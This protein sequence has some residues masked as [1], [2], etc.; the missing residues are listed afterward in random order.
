[1][2]NS[3]R[4]LQN[5]LMLYF[6]MILT[7]IIG[8]YTSRVVLI[9]LGISDYGLYNV[10]GGVVTMFTFINGSLAAGTQRF[11]TFELGEGTIDKLKEVFSTS[12]VIHLGLALLIL[13]I[14][15][16]IG[17]WFVLTKMN[18]EPT[19][20]HAALWVY[21]FSVIACVVSVIQ[22][23]FM[24]ALIAYEK[25][26]IYAYMVIYYSVIKLLIFFLL[27]YSPIDQL[28]F[29]AFLIMLVN[30][31][32]ALIY[33]IYCYRHYNECRFS[34]Y[35]NKDIFKKMFSFSVWDIIGSMA[36]IGQMQGVNIIINLFCGTVV[37]AARAISVT[38]NNIAI[39]FV[40]NFLMAV[41]PQIV[42]NY[43]KKQ[44]SEMFS[45][46]INSAKLGSYLFLFISIPVFIEIEFLLRIWLIEYP[47]YTPLFLR[48]ILIQS[49]IQ[50]LGIPTVRAMHA[51]GDI[52]LMNM[53]VGTVLF[54]IL[55]ISYLLFSIGLKPHIV[56]II[57]IFPWL[58]AIPIRLF[59]LYRYC[60]FPV[61]RF[62][63]EVLVYGCLIAFLCYIIPYIV[64]C[65]LPFEGGRRFIIVGCT[66][67]ISS[68]IVILF[69]GMT[70]QQRTEIINKIYVKFHFNR[71][72]Y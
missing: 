37:N 15:E 29:Y 8:L 46:V 43:A 72:S 69:I 14:A 68:S 16:T 26:S 33:N 45:L 6:R 24:S 7:M 63:L 51:I 36:S 57:N 70:K 40:N 64:H 21:Q 25:L 32:S 53:I 9:V 23:P 22:V 61:R 28:I 52:R 55:P 65:V 54:M 42:K 56:L 60:S 71:N 12:I 30:I 13:L 10:V 62:V 27:G 39:G 47:Q 2:V 35:F 4:I 49:W 66:S 31:S 50:T 19:R 5:T 48:I 3:R 1:M 34:T 59:L 44:M 58:I 38:V 20:F 18:F 41:T 67:I 11:L 17:L